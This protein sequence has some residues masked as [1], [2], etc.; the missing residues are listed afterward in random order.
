M[1]GAAS[2]VPEAATEG[3]R[4]VFRA[5]PRFYPN[6]VSHDA[7]VFIV[8]AEWGAALTLSI[9]DCTGR[10]VRDWDTQLGV[11]HGLGAYA[12]NLGGLASGVYLLT[13]AAELPGF[14]DARDERKMKLVV[15][16]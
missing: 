15:V 1:E 10:P 13:L 5:P 4:A 14:P 16:R 11:S 7:I 2:T 3:G 12:L 6:P 9:L 8:D